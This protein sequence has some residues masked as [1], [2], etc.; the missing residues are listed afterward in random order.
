MKTMNQL[1]SQ[2][3]IA[4]AAMQEAIDSDDATFA[5]AVAACKAIRA[6]MN[7]LAPVRDNGDTFS[8]TN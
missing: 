7:A 1:I 8:W 3:H 2:Y 6:Q 5:A 4:T